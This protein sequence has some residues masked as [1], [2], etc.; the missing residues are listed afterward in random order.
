MESGE[1]GR[2]IG[3]SE[4]GNQDFGFRFSILV[5]V[6]GCPGGQSRN[7]TGAGRETGLVLSRKDR[8][9]VVAVILEAGGTR[10]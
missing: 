7:G 4:P 3:V 5:L 2:G 9:V 6:L 1:R 10:A 8:F